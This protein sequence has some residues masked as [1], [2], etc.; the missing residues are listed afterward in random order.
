MKFFNKWNLINSYTI[1]VRKSINIYDPFWTI[2]SLRNAVNFIIKHVYSGGRMLIVNKFMY[3]DPRYIIYALHL[4]QLVSKSNWCAGS[5][6]NF[7][8]IF[9]NQF[10]ETTRGS[11]FLYM[12][13][14]VNYF[15]FLNKKNSERRFRDS[16]FRKLLTLRRF[17]TAAINFHYDSQGISLD[18]ECAKLGVPVVSVT[19]GYSNPFYTT[20]PV[21]GGLGVNQ[22]QNFFFM[23]VFMDAL[24][25]AS[26]KRF[27]RL[28]IML[29][30]FKRRAARLGGA[31][32]D[33]KRQPVGSKTSKKRVTVFK[34]N[35]RNV[36]VFFKNYPRYSF[37]NKIF[38]LFRINSEI[39]DFAKSAGKWNRTTAVGFSDPNSTIEL[40][41]KVSKRVKGVH[42]LRSFFTKLRSVK[43]RALKAAFSSKTA[44]NKKTFFH[45]KFSYLVLD[46]KPINLSK[47]KYKV[48]KNLR[49][50]ITS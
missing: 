47:P 44:P 37:G 10:F 9:N 17:P 16:I 8:K 32:K 28:Q 18:L 15:R 20:Y 27:K 12:Q 24:L 35:Y 6:S 42:V 7:F 14:V 29:D 38:K 2:L 50:Q 36:Y 26:Y 39:S 22:Q 45:K 11:T 34:R 30:G 23:N 5:I 49:N 33:S 21:I 41:R 43:A 48:L 25:F 13:K 31:G 19:E 4:N 40:S 46:K 3:L 1:G